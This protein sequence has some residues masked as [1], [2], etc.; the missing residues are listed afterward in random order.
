M[1]ILVLSYS[2]II[3]TIY[4]AILSVKSKMFLYH[5]CLGKKSVVN[6]KDILS[7]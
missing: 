4:I 5:L 2:L 1:K 6:C 7:L 3:S